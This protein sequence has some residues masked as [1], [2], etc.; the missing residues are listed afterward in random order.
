MVAGDGA[1]YRNQNPA[2]EQDP[3]GQMRGVLV[4]LQSESTTFERDYLLFVDEL[5]LGIRAIAEA[6]AV[7]SELASQLISA[8]PDSQPPTKAFT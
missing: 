1:Q 7:F 2:F 4:A 6:S 8:L 3:A 5:V